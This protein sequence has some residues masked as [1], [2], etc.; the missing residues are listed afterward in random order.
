M[1]FIS[2]PQALWHVLFLVQGPMTFSEFSVWAAY[3]EAGANGMIL[4]NN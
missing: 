4:V 2:F 3:M 1:L